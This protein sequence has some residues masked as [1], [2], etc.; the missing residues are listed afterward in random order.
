MIETSKRLESTRELEQIT[1]EYLSPTPDRGVDQ[2]VLDLVSDLVISRLDGDRILELGVGDRIWTPK[3]ID[4]FADVTSVDGSSGLLAA[5]QQ[6]LASRLDSKRWTPVCSLFEDYQPDRTFDTV[7]AT[8]VLEH[9]DDPGLILQ[10]ARQNWLKPGGKLA[11]VVPHA[12][13]LHRRLAVKMGL[14]TYPGELGETDRRMGHKHAFT[15]YE[16]EKLL[17]GAG[18]QI[19]EQK[20][21]FAK[22]LPNSMLAA[23]NDKQLRGL[24]ELGLDL[25]IEYS[26]TIYFLAEAKSS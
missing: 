6:D 7:L 1:V 18:F 11:V 16:M 24:F 21:M 10:M 13:S 20:G 22:V 15:C 19:V 25:P 3:L 12:L 8:F 23:C 17:V 4:K 26:T 14:A 9:V 5:M 2:K